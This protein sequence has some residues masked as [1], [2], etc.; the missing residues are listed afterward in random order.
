MRSFGVRFI[1]FLLAVCLAFPVM[2]ASAA[3][4]AVSI[5]LVCDGDAYYGGEIY[6]KIAVSKPAKALSGL[7][8]TLEYDPNHLAA[9]ITEN[10]E[11][12]REMN[13]LATVM[14][15]G[16]EQMSF[17]SE[18]LYK[19]RFAVCDDESSLL[20]AE[21]E[22]VLNI[23]FRIVTPGSFDFAVSDGDIIAVCADA[24]LS[25]MGGT[26][27]SISIVADS[28]AQ[29]LSAEIS[30]SDTAEENGTY[31]AD[32][33]VTNLGDVSGIIGVEFELDYDKNLFSPVITDNTKSQ[34]D[35][36]MADI[37]GS[38]E[39]MCSYDE[40][41]G[42]YLLRFAAKDAES[43]ASANKLASGK[44]MKISVPFT[45]VGDE[46][47]I[48]KFSV[49]S[50]SIVGINGGNGIITGSGSEKTILLEH[51]HGYPIPD[52]S[53]YL[54]HDGFLLYA[55]SA[56]LI[57]DFLAPFSNR[58]YLEY[59]G[60]SVNSGYVRTGHV[61]SDGEGVH[62][63][64]V[65]RGDAFDDGEINTYDYIAIK[66]YCMQTVSFSQAQLLASD[67]N[68]DGE[69]NTYDYILV[70]RHCMNTFDING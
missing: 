6:L 39:Q 38:W 27:G 43:A 18:G 8:F 12:G 16:W 40:K 57:G 51:A 70:K 2:G 66:R 21:N 26:G 53:N 14:P 42:K 32:I 22:L 28:E 54:V 33:T 29:K 60:N 7:E 41:S 5:T 9:V 35:A 20:D 13:A 61:L 45:V 30:G 25:L 64:L 11:D 10:T 68:S 65:V 44:T 34:M 4:S 52:G 48:G 50:A 55:P 1:V 47:S 58:L 36:F 3:D 56:T 31:N 19:F 49:S 24:D 37:P 46:G 23:P 67:I 17:H 59:N 15:K 63:I 69:I 62:L